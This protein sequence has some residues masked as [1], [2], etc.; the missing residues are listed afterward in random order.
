MSDVLSAVSPG[1]RSALDVLSYSLVL[2][3]TGGTDTFWS[4]AEIYFNC[5]AAG[6][7]A[8]ADVNAV[9]IQRATL[10][11]ANLG[12]SWNHI[13]GR[14]ELP[15]LA[16]ENVLAVEA[17]FTYAS[18]GEG[19]HYVTYPADGSACVYSKAY[20]GGARRIYCCFDQPDLRAAFTVSVKAPAGWSCLANAPVLS[21]PPDST[22]G[23][24]HG[25]AAKADL[26]RCWLQAS[27]RDLGEWA[28]ETLI[29]AGSA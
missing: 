14:L 27:G 25:N 2:D 17:E 10:N 4:R 28:A 8:F 12:G 18:A 22:A 3:L 9:S 7:G 13:D 23:T 29:P 1:C 5:G 11:G 20:R 26:V 21:R 15:R 19:L 6:F 16:G 24:A